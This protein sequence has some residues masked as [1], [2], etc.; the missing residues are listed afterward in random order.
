MLLVKDKDSL[1]EELL[2]DYDYSNFVYS[3]AVNSMRS[4]SFSVTRTPY[5][6]YTFDLLSNES[7]ITYKGQ[8][9]VIKSYS[10]SVQ[11]NIMSAQIVANHISYGCIDCVNYDV[12]DEA[13]TYTLEQVIKHAFSKNNLG[14]TY[15]FVGT[16]KSVK[17][18]KLGGTDALSMINDAYDQ[19]GCIMLANNKELIFY[20]IAEF[21]KQT[22]HVIRYK[23]NTDDVQVSSDTT[24]LKTVV[25]AYGKQKDSEDKNYNKLKTTDLSLSGEFNKKGTWYTEAIN[26]SYTAE[27]EAKWNG[28]SL[29]FKLKTDK[30]GGLWDVY[31]D[32]KKLKTLSCWSSSS[33]TET[34]VLV[35]SLTKGKHSIKF[36]FVGDD[37]NHPM[38]VVEKTK[39]IKG[40]KVKYKEKEKSR[41]YIGSE[42][43][44]IFTVVAN[45]NGENAYH[46]VTT[47]ESKNVAKWGRRYAEPINNEELT[48]VNSLKEYA[49]T[50]IQDDPVLSVTVSYKGKEES[51]ERDMWHIIHEPLG[52]DSPLKLVELRQFHPLSYLP[53]EMT[54]SNSKKDI[55]KLQRAL[56]K[57]VKQINKTSKDITNALTTI[58]SGNNNIGFD[59]EEVGEVTDG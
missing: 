44:V 51:S 9:Y 28:D 8:Q 6:A 41:G 34:L 47:Y 11:G 35:E 13:A 17:L 53:Q 52:F 49:A 24:A 42:K 29:S 43:T 25:K 33:K 4:I 3:W 56:F 23:Y 12:V 38:K 39:V 10:P 54:F 20:S 45:L 40:K 27:I 26:A 59:L 2:T 21:Y 7:V 14:Y 15:K 50:Q 48:T 30:L 37:P 58:G 55:V 22:E 5:N 32:D 31:I 57:N 36:I 18:E 1:Y 46:A 16:F 19:F